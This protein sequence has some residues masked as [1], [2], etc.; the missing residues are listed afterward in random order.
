[1][2]RTST[3]KWQRARSIA[4]KRALDEGRLNC[5]ICGVGM[6][7]TQS[8]SPN[9]IEADHILPHSLGGPDHPDNVQIICRT[10]NRRKGNGQARQ[11]RPIVRAD[12]LTNIDW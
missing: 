7:F 2:S 8:G 9:S 3:A 11:P 6:D 5:P 1:M 10:C 4:I 12:P